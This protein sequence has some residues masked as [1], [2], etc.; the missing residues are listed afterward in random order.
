MLRIRASGAAGPT[1]TQ[2]AP[3]TYGMV[4]KQP[5]QILVFLLP[6]V[7]LY[8]LG[9]AMLLRTEG[10][11][12]TVTAHKT[13]IDLFVTFGVTPTEGLFLGGMAIV[14]VLLIWHLLNRDPW[15]IDPVT[16]GLMALESLLLTVPLIVLGLI[17]GGSP[18]AVGVTAIGAGEPPA[19]VEIASMSIWS[20]LAISIGA[21]LYEELLFRM[22]LIAVLHTMLVDVGKIGSGL[23]AAIA[24]GISAAAFTWY[25]PLA[26]VHGGLAIEKTVFYF[27]AGLYFGAVY[28]LRGFGIVVGVHV[29]Y[30]IVTVSM[31]HDP[32]GG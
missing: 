31:L 30:D 23:G 10:G 28:V 26:D 22:L 3:G 14:I 11:V 32:A 25:H 21:G 20:K 18:D 24:V 16:P 29:I 5:L 2:P 17:I 12:R 8:E 15:H 1:K 6:L 9:L 4:S 7:I 27:L 13:I 19:S